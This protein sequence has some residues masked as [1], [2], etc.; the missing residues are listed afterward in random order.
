MDL[1]A[2]C[3]TKVFFCNSLAKFD[4]R[5]SPNFFPVLLFYVYVGPSKCKSIVPFHFSNLNW[6]DTFGNCQRTSILTWCVS[7][8]TNLWKL[9][10]NWSL[11]IITKRVVSL[12]IYDFR[13]K[14]SGH[15]WQL[16]KTSLLTWCISTYA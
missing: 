5:L 7:I 3:A 11:A 16:S 10:L 15:Y 9:R 4:D 1:K 6:Q 2:H 14:A 8:V 12:K 13:I